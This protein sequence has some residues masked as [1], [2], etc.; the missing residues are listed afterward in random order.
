MPTDEFLMRCF[1]AGIEFD[2][3]DKFDGWRA[4]RTDKG[5]VTRSLKPI[6]NIHVREWMEKYVPVGFDGELVSGVFN[7]CQSH[8]SSFDVIAPFTYHVFDDYTYSHLTYQ[9]R[10]ERLYRFQHT[11]SNKIQLDDA[12]QAMHFEY[13]RRVNSFAMLQI[14]EAQAVEERKREGLILRV[15]WGKYKFGRSTMSEALMLKLK[16]WEDAEAVIVGFE[17]LMRNLNTPELDA[18]GRQKRGHGI[19]NKHADEMLGAFIVRHPTFGIFNIGGPFTHLQRCKFWNEQH[20]LRGSLVTF[21]FQRHG[22]LI[23]PRNPVFKCLRM[24]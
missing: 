13:P 3:T 18:F 5:P 12:A 4:I 24:D 20:L 14:E 15:P 1:E 16:R 2:V 10:V 19:A 23:K 8:F 21:K 9:E 6:P 11:L 22:T 7:E 17:P